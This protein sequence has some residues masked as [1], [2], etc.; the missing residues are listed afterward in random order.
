[1]EPFLGEIRLM[2]GNFAPKGWAQCNGQMLPLNQYT[3][4]YSLLGT[5][6]G[7]DG[8]TTFG[9]PDLRSRTPIGSDFVGNYPMGSIDGTESVSLNA[10]QIPAHTHTLSGTIKVADMYTGASPGDNYPAASSVPQYG[11]GTPNVNL[12]GVNLG[13]ATEAMGS[14][15]P[16]NNRQPVLALNYCIALTGIFPS[17]G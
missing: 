17:R 4:L 14:G 13:T 10:T 8:R 15:V 7:G 12:N 1:M 2:G 5:S 16:H 11:S 3:A 9:L 6:Y